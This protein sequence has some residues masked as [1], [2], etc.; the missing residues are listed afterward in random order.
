MAADAIE[1]IAA[2]LKGGTDFVLASHA[3]PDGDSI[4]SQLALAHA[5]RSLGK[6]VRIVNR[7]APPAYLHAIPGV[8]DIEAAGAGRRAFRCGGRA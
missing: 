7:D 6:A 5:L 1:R 3:R 8:T 2:A 4:G